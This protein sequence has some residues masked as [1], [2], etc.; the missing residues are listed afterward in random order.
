MLTA[1]LKPDVLYGLYL[2]HFDT[3]LLIL[4]IM[5]SYFIYI[6]NYL[7][8]IGKREIGR[9]PYQLYSTLKFWKFTEKD[10]CSIPHANILC[11]FSFKTNCSLLPM[12]TVH[13]AFVLFFLKF[14]FLAWLLFYWDLD[15]LA[16]LKLR[17]YKFI[18]V[19]NVS[20]FH[21]LVIFSNN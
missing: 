7:Y 4:F 10:S 15:W 9:G 12:P 6:Y 2:K 3:F 20:I 1:A 8:F 5:I 16:G 21:N 17:Y 14:L 13:I 18:N 11:P 19:T